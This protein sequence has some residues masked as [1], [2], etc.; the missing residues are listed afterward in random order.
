MTQD[1]HEKL[2]RYADNELD[3]QERSALEAQIAGSPE[4]AAEVERWK[5]LRCCAG[6]A[7]RDCFV[8]PGFEAR[9]RDKVNHAGSFSG[10]RVYRI[11]NWLAAAAAI[12]LF[13]VFWS[14]RPKVVQPGQVQAGSISP[15]TLVEVYESCA[16]K[17]HE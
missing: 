8:S 15:A 4:L 10:S 17:H 5:A 3:A 13:A 12:V 2:A 9:L 7:M 16:K 6:R 11:S 1:L 14:S